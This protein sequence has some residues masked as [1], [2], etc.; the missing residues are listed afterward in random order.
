MNL[1][2]VVSWARPRA[3]IIGCTVEG[4]AIAVGDEEILPTWTAMCSPHEGESDRANYLRLVAAVGS[5]GWTA[6]HLLAR[7]VRWFHS[8]RVARAR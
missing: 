4:T 5:V 8:R 1:D 3:G 7:W 6:V 2:A